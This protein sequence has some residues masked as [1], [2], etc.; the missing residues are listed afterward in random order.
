MNEVIGVVYKRTAQEFSLWSRKINSA[1]FRSLF[2]RNNAENIGKRH[3][4]LLEF[5]SRISSKVRED[6][7]RNSRN[8]LSLLLH[9]TI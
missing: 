9:S 1:N 7:E 8:S 2:L 3:L 6:E 4:N 5:S